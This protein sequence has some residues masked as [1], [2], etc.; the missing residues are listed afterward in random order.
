M[1]ACLARCVKRSGNLGRSFKVEKYKSGN[2]LRGNSSA[3]QSEAL[4]HAQA[5]A[6]TNGA[7]V[8]RLV[9]GMYGCF[10]SPRRCFR[11]TGA[12]WFMVPAWFSF[13][14]AWVVID[15]QQLGI[16]YLRNFAITT[17]KG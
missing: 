15:P 4:V 5:N 12:R 1:K 11:N 16:S 8:H 13:K 14:L 17:G 10:L 6:L 3:W 9:W 2:V 7:H